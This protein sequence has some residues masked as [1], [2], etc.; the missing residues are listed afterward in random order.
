MKIA[1][2]IGFPVAMKVDSPDISHKSDV[3]CVRLGVADRAG[4][5][6][7]YEELLS[8]A[9][10]NC[11]DASVSGVG[12]Y[13]MASQGM[14]MIIGVKTDPQFG[15]LIMAGMGG[16]FAEALNDVS[17]ALAPLSRSEASDL[18]FSLKGS[19][20]LSRWRGSEPRDVSSLIGAVMA[21][22]DMAV[23][24]KDLMP[25]ADLNPIMVYETGAGVIAVDALLIVDSGGPA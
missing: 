21:V 7:A 3:G 4:L 25:E 16:V 17:I 24:M 10:V 22:S 9:R 19:K 13:K 15:P 20:L 8:N 23:G 2:A 6:R 1:G 12:V 5:E 11:P 14:E 18:V